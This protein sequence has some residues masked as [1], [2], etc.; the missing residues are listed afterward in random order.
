MSRRSSR[1]CFACKS[2]YGCANGS[3]VCHRLE[4][5]ELV[6]TSGRALRWEFTVVEEHDRDRIGICKL[7]GEGLSGATIVDGE[8]PCAGRGAS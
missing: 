1:C 5:D 7:C 8:T 3:C 2:P 4:D 6:N